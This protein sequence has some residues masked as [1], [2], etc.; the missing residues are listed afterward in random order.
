MTFWA[1]YSQRCY[2]TKH[3]N[4]GRCATHHRFSGLAEK[5]LRWMR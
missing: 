4:T 2:G 5:P 1:E 3:K